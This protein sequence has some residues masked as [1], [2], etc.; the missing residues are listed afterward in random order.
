MKVLVSTENMSKQDWLQWRNKGIGGS[1]ASIICGINKYKS[2]VELWME[3]TGM[4]GPVEAGEAAYWGTMI[5]P[6]I[7]DEFTRRTG[8]RVS[9]EKSMF[10]H[11]N[12]PFMLANVDGIINDDTFGDCIF[13]AKTSSI[14]R[15]NEW[16][17]SIPEEYQLQVQHYMAVTGLKGAYVAVLMGGNQYKYQFIPRDEELIQ[18]LIKLENLFWQFVQTKTPPPMDGSKSCSDFLSRFYPDSKPTS[19]IS[20]PEEALTLIKQYEEYEAKEKEVAL[21]KEEAANKL[22]NMLGDNESGLII[23]RKITWKTMSS[24]RLDSKTLKLDHPEIYKNYTYKS[25]FRRFSL[26]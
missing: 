14:Y 2:P 9:I 12:Y 5:E 15:Q 18:V 20:L 26:K 25:T 6:L 10:Q 13:E 8:L 22:K 11:P 21:I 1:D 3:K 16:D 23:D 4:A 7:R 19:S 17:D 24:E